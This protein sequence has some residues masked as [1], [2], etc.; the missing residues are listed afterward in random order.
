MKCGRCNGE[1]GQLVT[2]YSEECIV[3][4]KA[5]AQQSEKRIMDLKDVIVKLDSHLSVARHRYV[6]Y[7]WPDD[8]IREVDEAIAEARR[9]TRE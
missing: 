9:L 7:L 1:L 5:A 2:H 4:L 6:G 3:V 8:L